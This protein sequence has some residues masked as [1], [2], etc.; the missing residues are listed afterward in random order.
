MY[1]LSFVFQSV[2]LSLC[3]YLRLLSSI[4]VISQMNRRCLTT[5]SALLSLMK[6]VFHKSPAF[7][8]CNQTPKSHP[9]APLDMRYR[10]SSDPETHIRSQINQPGFMAVRTLFLP[11]SS[12]SPFPLHLLHQSPTIFRSPLLRFRCCNQFATVVNHFPRS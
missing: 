11:P 8:R 2:C 3:I 7:P 9:C 12:I 4:G 1:V 5:S 10:V 6:L